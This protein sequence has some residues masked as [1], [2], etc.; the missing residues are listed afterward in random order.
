MLSWIWRFL[1]ISC[2]YSNK[3][4]EM[5]AEFETLYLPFLKICFMFRILL[6]SFFRNFFLL[7][8]KFVPLNSQIIDG[9]F[10]RNPLGVVNLCSGEIHSNSFVRDI[11]VRNFNRENSL[12]IFVD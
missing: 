7:S 3:E 11:S 6:S 5:E 8:R 12:F 9:E 1:K 2:E 4:F 10:F